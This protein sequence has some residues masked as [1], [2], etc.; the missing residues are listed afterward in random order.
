[1]V[2]LTLLKS[3]GSGSFNKCMHSSG[4]HIRDAGQLHHLEKFLES[5]ASSCPPFPSPWPPLLSLL[6]QQLSHL[7]HHRVTFESGFF[8]LVN[9]I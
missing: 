8:H 3:D 7:Q 6:S 4:H 9:L 2:T 5:F 1:M